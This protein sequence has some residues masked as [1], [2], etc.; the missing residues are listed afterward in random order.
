[1]D[2]I[3]WKGE[4]NGNALGYKAAF[5]RNI[6]F[7]STRYAMETSWK[8]EIN[9]NAYKLQSCSFQELM[10]YSNGRDKL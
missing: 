7:V 6:Y 5:F 4:I 2:V 8:E 1:M 9:E 3:S 10:R